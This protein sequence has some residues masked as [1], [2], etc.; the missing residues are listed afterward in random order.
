MCRGIILNEQEPIF[1]MGRNPRRCGQ[2]PRQ[3]G[4]AAPFLDLRDENAVELALLDELELAE[5]ASG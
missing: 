4:I 5:S 1:E 2:L 3:L